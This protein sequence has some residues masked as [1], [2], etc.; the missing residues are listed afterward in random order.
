M[1]LPGSD[2]SERTSPVLIRHVAR[3]L[4]CGLQYHICDA[5][6]AWTLFSHDAQI[7][8]SA[9]RALPTRKAHGRLA[10]GNALGRNRDIV[11]GSPDRDRHVTRKTA[12]GDFQIDT[13]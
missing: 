10:H 9:V 13:V 3:T 2:F 7:A 4:L 11:R 1:N 8:A 5:L 12:A 6:L